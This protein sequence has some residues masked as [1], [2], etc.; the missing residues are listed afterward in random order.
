MDNKNKSLGRR[1]ALQL[2]GASGL[3][4]GGIVALPGCN[5]KKSPSAGPEKSSAAGTGC[6]TPV[7]DTSANLRRT[8]QYKNPATDPTKQCA[9]CAQF[10][11]DQ[12]GECGGCKLF[13]GPVNP[14]GGCLSF[15]PLSSDAGTGKT[16]T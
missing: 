8:L 16:P 10:S 7:D 15:A 9:Q 11:K 13:T 4:A 2:L 3:V 1:R 6:N 12:F 14:K 5:N